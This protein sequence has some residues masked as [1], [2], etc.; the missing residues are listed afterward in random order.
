MT[1]PAIPTGSAW[2]EAGSDSRHC[3]HMV[4][5]RA[6]WHSLIIRPLSA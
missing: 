1:M 6:L 3:M 4:G 2:T 5:T